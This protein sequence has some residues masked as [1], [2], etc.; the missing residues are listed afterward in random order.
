MSQ[1]IA[2][3]GCSIQTVQQDRAEPTLVGRIE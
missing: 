2:L 3:A 1:G